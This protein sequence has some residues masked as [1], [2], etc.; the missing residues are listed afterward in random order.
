M[1]VRGVKGLALLADSSASSDLHAYSSL[2]VMSHEHAPPA[3]GA[4][5][6]MSLSVLSHWPGGG[7]PRSPMMMVPSLLV[8]IGTCGKGRVAGP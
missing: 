6:C 1:F 3:P 2:V 8:R 7:A 5:V 4:S